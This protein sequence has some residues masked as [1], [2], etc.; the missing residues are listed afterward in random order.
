MILT[1]T[2]TVENKNIKEYRGIVFGEVVTGIDFV[3]DFGA[4]I[5]NFFGGR[6]EEYEEELVNA[7]ADAINEM[8]KKAEK[9][10]ANALVGVTVNTE[11]MPM[12]DNRGSML[13]VTV[14]G[15]AV[16]ID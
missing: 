1:T 15:T 3:R 11:S 12:A 14:S 6:S 4:S 10:G 13:V 7:R 8:I 2:S 5:T 16:V 9:I